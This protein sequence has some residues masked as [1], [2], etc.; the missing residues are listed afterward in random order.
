MCN[1]HQDNAQWMADRMGK[2]TAS[3]MH[4]AMKWLKNNKESNERFEYKMDVVTERLTNVPTE[5]Y[6]SNDMVWGKDKEE[7]AKE[8]YIE[9]TGKNVINVGFINHPTI[10]YCGASPDGFVEDGLVEIK[11][12]KSKTHLNY[13]IDDKVPEKY[14]AQMIL[15]MMC[16]ERK[17]CDFVSYDP[18]LPENMQIFIKRYEPTEQELFKV[19]E[20]ANLF[21]MDVE[22]IINNIKKFAGDHHG[23]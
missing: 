2:L 9:I 14:K 20:E 21:L 8:A 22:Y 13:I 16:T 11:C 7:D 4:S 23:K 5:F 3:R 10:D 1:E 12:P 15:Q 17:W 18:R 19:S 6:V